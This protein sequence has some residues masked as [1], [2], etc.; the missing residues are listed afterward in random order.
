MKQVSFDQQP[1]SVSLQK[2]VEKYSYILKG[3]LCMCGLVTPIWTYR[4]NVGSTRFCFLC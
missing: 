2:E 3:E 4:F 1:S